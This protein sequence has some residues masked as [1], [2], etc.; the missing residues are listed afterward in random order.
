MNSGNQPIKA[1]ALNE[2]LD[3]DFA[4]QAA[5]LGVWELDLSNN[6]I[7]WDD[8]CRTLFGINS[9]E[10]QLS[11]TDAIKHVHPDDT[12]RV[13]KAVK[14][15]TEP[16][17]N[18]IYDQTYR[19]IGA[20]DG[21]LRWVRFHGKS[22]FDQEGKIT[23]FAGVAQDVTS[24]MTA[25][26]KIRQ[27]EERYR[28]LI[29]QAPVATM[30]MTGEEHTIE[31]ANQKMIEMLGKGQ[32]IVGRPASE[33]VPELSVQPYMQL[34][35]HVLKSGEPYK[36]NGMPGQLVKEGV[37][38]EHYFD[39]T[40]QPLRNSEGEIYGILAMAVDVTH[41]KKVELENQIKTFVLD[42][43]NL[44][45]GISPLGL[46]PEPDYNNAFTLNKL[47]WSD[48]K[49]RTLLDAIYPEDREKATKILPEF[50]ANGK[51]TLEI[52]LWNELTG[53]PFWIEWN[54]MVITDPLTNKPLALATISPD[55]T[56]RKAN[57]L[58]LQEREAI[59]TDAVEIAQ[60]GT[61]SLDII[62]QVTQLSQRHLD[63]FG[64]SGENL[65]LE[66]AMS[67]VVK[68][69]LAR[70][71]NAF[72]AA[73]KP[74][75]NGRYQAE[76]AIVNATTGK[77]QIIQAVG[78]THFDL[79]GTP[80]RVVG[81]ALDVTVQREI[82]SSLEGLVEQ[83]TQE[84][85]LINEELAASNEEYT[86]LNVE[87]AKSNGL[88][89]RS[90]DHLQ[91]FAYVASHDL[92]EPL[93]KIQQFG[94]LLKGSLELPSQKTNDYLEKMQSA[95]RR[96][97]VLIED[98]LSFSSIT[99]LPATSEQVSLTKIMELIQSDQEFVIRETHSVLIIDSLPVISGNASQIEQLF[100]NL[101]SNA[102][103][104]RKL[105]DSIN[106]V[107]TVHVSSRMVRHTD[108]PDNVRPVGMA[109]SYHQIDVA[110]SGI[111]FDEAHLDRIFQVFQRLHGRSEYKGT[112]IGL[113][114]CEKVVSNHGGAIT[115]TSKPGQGATFH[116]YLPAI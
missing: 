80:V 3:L 62:T 27:S 58:Y 12:V 103:K 70:V 115:A 56:E 78:K 50:L 37:T 53:E 92:Q 13:E 99:V 23:R 74:G 100:Q 35:D 38:S 73:Q 57:L 21:I 105:G 55:I 81:I 106:E 110:D 48:N 4:L 89:I 65:T 79:D 8:R 34:L 107:N 44:I 43:C 54:V 77:K 101:I 114:I 40:Y 11:Y 98:L 2:R 5:G 86:A 112:G 94:G 109:R 82:Q 24:Q 46:N 20:D 61:W 26:E 17:S 51:G 25:S 28:L 90:N 42:S 111:G 75:S 31:I 32:A 30:V 41:L 97:S 59:L 19:T 29:H 16:G 91:R 67:C 6:R 68:E 9:G 85:A 95:A 60:L 1:K 104:F 15:A 116:V 71:S 102:L 96:M 66:K 14:G 84:L 36:A 76:F 33:A 64:I 108:L 83:R 10:S 88:L 49:N 72:I 47:G 87:L 93:R 45:I 7:F 63:M 52:R 39:F 69:D 22:Y 113:A 18:G